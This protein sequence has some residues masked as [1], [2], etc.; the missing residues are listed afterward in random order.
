M[1]SWIKN[2]L[3]ER[4][5]KR[6]LANVESDCRILYSYG[7]SIDQI[8]DIIGANIQKAGGS[9]PDIDRILRNLRRLVTSYHPINPTYFE[10]VP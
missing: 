3:D 2:K 10:S 8:T 1:I 5:T 4:K 6:F 9:Q 7:F